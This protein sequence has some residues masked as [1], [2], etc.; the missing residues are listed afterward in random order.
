MYGYLIDNYNATDQEIE[1]IEELTKLRSK[2]R[3]SPYFN[4]NPSIVIDNFLFHG[5]L[6]HASNLQLLKQLDIRHIIN[7]CD[8]PLDKKIM[9]AFN[10]LHIN[11][12]D[13]MEVDIKQH[14]DKTNQFLKTCKEKNEKVLVH[15]QMGIS[16]SST[17]VLAYLMKYHHDTLFKAYDFLLDKRRQAS[18]NHG[19]LLQLIRYEQELRA[20]KEIDTGKGDIQNPIEI[21]ETK[22]EDKLEL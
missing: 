18:P 22:V 11:L 9:S 13:S 8:F 4:K 16:R 7:I 2:R 6:G 19:F 10:V 21:V 5:D 12:D 1:Y 20:T 3:D 15:C 14:F 17:I